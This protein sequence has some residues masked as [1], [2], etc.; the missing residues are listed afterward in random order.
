MVSLRRWN[1]LITPEKNPAP[2]PVAD[3]SADLNR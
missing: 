2:V 3:L 1:R